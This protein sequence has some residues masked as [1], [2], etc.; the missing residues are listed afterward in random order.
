MNDPKP[1]QHRT[2]K[3]VLNTF[4]YQRVR[5]FLVADEVGLGKTVVA[6]GILED[7]LK[8]KRSRKEGPLRVF[9]M[10]NSLA[11]ARQ[12]RDNL[13]QAVP[14][15][16]DAYKCVSRVDRLTLVVANIL[17]EIY[18]LHLYSLTPGTSLPDRKG[19]IATGTA[20]ERALIHNILRRR[21]PDLLIHDGKDWLQQHA[22]SRW[23]YHKLNTIDL[24]K[25]VEINKFFCELRVGLKLKRGQHLP[26]RVRRYLTSGKQ[27]ELIKL[28]RIALANTGLHQVQP[29]VVILDEFQRYA[30]I[31]HENGDSSI[32][33]RMLSKEGPAVLLL[34]ATPYRL[35]KD[36]KIDASET[37][38]SQHRYYYSLIEWLFG[39]EGDGT[40][41]KETVRQLFDRYKKSLFSND[42]FGEETLKNKREIESTLRP[43]MART[44]RPRESALEECTIKTPLLTDDF[45]MFQELA[46]CFDTGKE[47]NQSTSGAVVAYW[48][49]VPLPLQ[50]LGPDY[51]AW[52][53]WSNSGFKPEPTKSILLSK[54]KRERFVAP[55]EWPHH[56]LRALSTHFGIPSMSIPWVAPSMPWWPLADSWSNSGP[57]KALVFSRFK[58]IPRAISALVSYDVELERF[59]RYRR[60]Y[61]QVSNR[62]P[63]SLSYENLAF[64]HVS[65]FLS[66][67]VDP[68]QFGC[69]HARALLSEATRELKGKLK[70]MDVAVVRKRAKK[71]RSV[72]ELLVRLERT[73]GSWDDSLKCW[74]E[75]AEKSTSRTI[76]DGLKEKIK[77]WDHSVEGKLNNILESEI[78]ALAEL[79]TAS[80]GQ[81]VAR[82]FERHCP[83]Y[84]DKPWGLA[85]A[86]QASW[87][88]LRTYFNHTWMDL[89]CGRRKSKKRTIRDQIR[90]AVI[91]GNLESVL[92]EHL[93]VSG[94]LRNIDEK[95]LKDQLLNPLFLRATSVRV[96]NPGDNRSKH[97]NLRTH[98][99]FAFA[100]ENRD[101]TENEE[102]AS[103]VRTEDIRIAF[104]SPFWPF[105]VVSTSVG[106]EGLDFHTWCR[107]VV[108]WDLPGN[109]VD[110]EQ[111]EGRIDRYAGLSTRLAAIQNFKLSRKDV[112]KGGSPWKAL[113]EKA[114]N[115]EVSGRSDGLAPWW[116]AENARVQNFVFDVP[117][118]EATTRLEILKRQR[119]L[120]RLALGQPNQ[121]DF[122][123]EL[124]QHVRGRVSL[125][126]VL[127]ATINLGEVGYE[128]REM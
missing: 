16:I 79:A 62:T 73:A 49:S 118:S 5:R 19:R 11:I 119:L 48:S 46:R 37:D 58:A 83:G 97:F 77:A 35:Y 34:S 106:Q 21:Y 121:S 44:E 24:A 99:A 17:P 72:P 71:A 15:G 55:K 126:H 78:R 51:K 66:R 82:S 94:V 116:I 61:S 100:P 28:F 42:P 9:Y 27:R 65:K 6:R 23:E 114:E 127:A 87:Q 64:F 84:L 122:I 60:K 109:A 76:A 120:Y 110:L 111:R 31:L 107:S 63:V 93:W 81:V 108:H 56:K 36:R 22:K 25:K 57:H 92:D 8:N 80:P 98:A 7:M 39:G 103:R 104:N 10:C 3:R 85:G 86:L 105:V 89:M 117:T 43:V 91:H 38:E 69:V 101:R 41:K 13:L 102:S 125:E 70:E 52:Q 96:Q 74:F 128:E 47:G 14:A 12:N 20:K 67:S 115:A 45:T 26:L 33:N 124:E 50:M 123:R 95:M 54:G 113:A 90:W 18:P 53:Q 2:I 68:W 30:N 40:I 29:D 75:V 1:F 88:G 112:R 4:Y 59:R 32:A